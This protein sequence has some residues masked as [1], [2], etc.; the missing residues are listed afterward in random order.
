LATQILIQASITIT[1]PP[2]PVTGMKLIGIPLSNDQQKRNYTF[3]IEELEQ[4]AGERVTLA[5]EFMP[6]LRVA[7]SERLGRLFDNEEFQ[8][9]Y[10]SQIKGL[11]HPSSKRRPDA[12]TLEQEA[13]E[14]SLQ[15]VASGARVFLAKENGIVSNPQEFEKELAEAL[16]DNPELPLRVATSRIPRPKLHATLES[17]HTTVA[18]PIVEQGPYKGWRMLGAYERQIILGDRYKDIA[19][20]TTLINGSTEVSTASVSHDHPITFGFGSAL[21][22][23]VSQVESPPPIVSHNNLKGPLIGVETDTVPKYFG[24]GIPLMVLAPHP[25]L[26]RILNLRNGPI[27]GGLT[28]LDKKGHKAIIARTWRAKFVRGNDFGMPTP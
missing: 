15:E 24:L 27:L 6:Q 1:P 7:V 13:V 17:E 21:L 25:A 20:K 22:W 26:I 8:R 9:S 10:S 19:G 5:E 12:Y 18:V 14:R 3:A 23:L 28:L 4:C 2:L 16:I 11:T